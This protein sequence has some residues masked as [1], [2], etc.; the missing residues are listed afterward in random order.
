MLFA[1]VITSIGYLQ[2][3]E[4]PFVMTA[5]GPLNSTLTLTMYVYEQGFHFF[6]LGY[7]SAM[8]YLLF[9]AIALLTALQFRVLRTQT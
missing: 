5:G 9:I 1:A 7:A 2:V 8:A 4:E 3:M 6:N